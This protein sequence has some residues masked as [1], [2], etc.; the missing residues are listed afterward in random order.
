[1]V[2]VEMGTLV[3]SSE[4]R[5]GTVVKLTRYELPHSD[6]KDKGHSDEVCAAIRPGA[7]VSVRWQKDVSKQTTHVFYDG[8]GTSAMDF[9]A[10]EGFQNITVIEK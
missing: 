10:P 5:L 3:Q 7:V 2:K 1:M 9:N 6:W 8:I 4:E